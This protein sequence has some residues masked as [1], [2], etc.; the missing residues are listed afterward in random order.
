MVGGLERVFE[1]GRIFRNEGVSARH[2][3]EFTT[4]EAYQAGNCVHMQTLFR[5]LGPSLLSQPM[6]PVA[7]NQGAGRVRLSVWPGIAAHIQCSASL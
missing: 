2:N 5:Q 3:P 6:L 1:I 4:V 7:T